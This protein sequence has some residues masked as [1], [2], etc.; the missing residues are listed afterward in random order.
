MDKIKNQKL[1]FK[2]YYKLRNYNIII[3]RYIVWR[4]IWRT[5]DNIYYSSVLLI[6]K[7]NTAQLRCITNIEDQL[8][9]HEQIPGR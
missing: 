5:I 9:L 4:R 7:Y 6:P 1:R 8:F 2:N 3:Y